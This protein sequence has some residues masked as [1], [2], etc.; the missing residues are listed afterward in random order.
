MREAITDANT[1]TLCLDLGAHCGV[2]AEA[3]LRRCQPQA[4]GSKPKWHGGATSMAAAPMLCQLQAVESK[5]KRLEVWHILE[6]RGATVST[7]KCIPTAAADRGLV[8]GSRQ[9]G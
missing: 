7:W 3:A 1:D 4:V 2:E 6:R 5:R 9:T 8:G